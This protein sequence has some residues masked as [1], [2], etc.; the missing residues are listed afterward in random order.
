MNKGTEKF[1]SECVGVWG[2]MN[3]TKQ[4]DVAS[5][6]KFH[7]YKLSVSASC[8]RHSICGS[9]AKHIVRTYLQQI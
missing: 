1:H 4:H 9:K 8:A 7:S 3:N 5:E 2:M 6:T